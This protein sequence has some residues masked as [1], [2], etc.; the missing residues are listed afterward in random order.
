MRVRA[1]ARARRGEGEGE[2]GEEE[3]EVL[4]ARGRPWVRDGS[5]AAKGDRDAAEWRSGKPVAWQRATRSPLHH[6]TPNFHRPC[7]LTN[8]SDRH[9]I[10]QE[11]RARRVLWIPSKSG[12]SG[13]LILV[14]NPKTL[15]VQIWL[16][17][18]CAGFRSSDS[19]RRTNP[20]YR[21]VYIEYSI[22]V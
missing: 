1:R 9:Q 12:C 14:N 3:G 10:W 6:T 19:E 8:T 20:G 22:L 4:G 15:Q 11:Y 7:A 13:S 16:L 2:G 18:T 5:L 17:T 21:I